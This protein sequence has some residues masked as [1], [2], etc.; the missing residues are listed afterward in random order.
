LPNLFVVE[1]YAAGAG[2]GGVLSQRQLD[3]LIAYLLTL[4]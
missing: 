3:D 2:C 4:E 1:G